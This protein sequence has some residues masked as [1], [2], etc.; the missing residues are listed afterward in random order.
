MTVL[1][2][3]I[4]DDAL[5]LPAQPDEVAGLV[6][7][8]VPSR[9]VA[10]VVDEGHGRGRATALALA[11][12]GAAVVIAGEDEHAVHAVAEEIT[13]LGG[14]ARAH[15]LRPA[16][17]EDYEM[18]VRDA[19]AEF[20]R[21]DWAV[22]STAVQPVDA[23]LHEL[24]DRALA[25]LVTDRLAPIAFGL[26]AVTGHLV[27]AGGGHTS[28]IVTISSSPGPAG[29]AHTGCAVLT[30]E[31]AAEYGALGIRINGIRAENIPPTPSLPVED[32]DTAPGLSF[33]I[34][35]S[36]FRTTPARSPAASASAH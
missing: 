6:D 1:T 5:E 26:R 18:I 19:V 20:G 16:C 2:A 21:L 32:P 13:L 35:V 29:H 14:S 9:K 28:A 11:A 27:A 17:G 4:P 22:L 15:T 12:R 8:E 10:I 34:W 36:T 30:Q 24:S 3:H 23:S 7:A 25:H 33:T 31:A